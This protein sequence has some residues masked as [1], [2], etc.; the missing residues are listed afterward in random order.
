[1]YQ[2]QSGPNLQIN[3]GA[4]RQYE[5]WYHPSTITSGTQSTNTGDGEARMWV[6]GV[7]Q[8]HD[9]PGV[10]LNGTVNMAN[11]EV[12]VGGFIT[13]FKT[14]LTT[15]CVPFTACPGPAPGT[16]APSAYHRYIDDVIVMKK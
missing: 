5:L 4:W 3:A 7:L 13:S 2:Y 6:N 1:Q 15:R 9:G 10:N 12:H 16:G 8:L 11:S 14:D